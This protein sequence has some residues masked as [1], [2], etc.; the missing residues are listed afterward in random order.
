MNHLH[1]T[2]NPAK[3]FHH[4]YELSEGTLLGLTSIA[5]MNALNMNQLDEIPSD[6]PDLSDED[7]CIAYLDRVANEV[8]ELGNQHLRKPSRAQ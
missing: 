7:A 8:A 5:I 1:I 4:L 6:L 3:Y 2:N